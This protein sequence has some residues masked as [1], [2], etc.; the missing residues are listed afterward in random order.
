MYVATLKK[1]RT[2]DLQKDEY[3]KKTI[4]CTIHKYY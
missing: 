2:G 3:W 1:Q 4:P